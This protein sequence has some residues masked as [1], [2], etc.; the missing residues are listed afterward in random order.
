[1]RAASTTLLAKPG[2]HSA[3]PSTV[4]SPPAR[5][6]QTTSSAPCVT[7]GS[8]PQS[9]GLQRQH[10]PTPPQ[11]H[12]RPDTP[13]RH[14]RTRRAGDRSISPRDHAR[15]PRCRARSRRGRGQPVARA[16]SRAVGARLTCR[17]GPPVSFPARPVVRCH[18]RHE[19]DGVPAH[20]ASRTDGTA[21]GIHG[22]VSCRDRTRGRLAQPVPREPVL[23]CPLRVLADRVPAS[24]ATFIAGVAAALLH[25]ARS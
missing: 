18:G 23:P 10:S 14:R 20:D 4:P 5:P 24:P 11:E 12:D 15:A 25:L 22:P 9:F 21:V 13:Y 19:P 8:S 7:S 2:P 17:C 3:S 16:D 1:M 6:A